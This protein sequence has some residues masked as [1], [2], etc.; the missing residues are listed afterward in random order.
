ML[1]DYD[2]ANANRQLLITVGT[3]YWIISLQMPI[4]NYSWHILFNYF[5]A[6]GNANC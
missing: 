6:N 1:L 5:I 2:I 3:C 4:A